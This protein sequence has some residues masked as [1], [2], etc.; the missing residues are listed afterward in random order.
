MFGEEV[1]DRVVEFFQEYFDTLVMLADCI[2]CRSNKIGW[3]CKIVL[4]ERYLKS[5]S[6]LVDKR[7]ILQ[8]EFQK[9]SDKQIFDRVLIL[10]EEIIVPLKEPEKEYFKVLPMSL[11][12]SFERYLNI[13]N[14]LAFYL[15]YKNPELGYVLE[16]IF[17]IF[18]TTSSNLYLAY[19]PY[20]KSFDKKH[21]EVLRKELKELLKE[22]KDLMK[23]AK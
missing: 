15:N 7:K 9:V 3:D 12:R 2:D 14:N 21:A 20:H 17:A 5:L 22:F 8:A 1:D 6:K 16:K 19:D 13:E 18:C 10:F 23:E 11:P 4:N